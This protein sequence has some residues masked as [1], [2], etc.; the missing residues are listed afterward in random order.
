M[1]F[2]LSKI[3]SVFLQPLLW[4]LALLLYS[5][6]GKKTLWKR[7]SLRLGVALLIVLTN[8]LLF[9]ATMR[10][11]EYKSTD[12]EAITSPYDVG[13]LLGGY[14]NSYILPEHDRHN[15]NAAANR[16]TQTLELYRQGKIKKILLSGGSGKIIP[17]EVLE[18][19]KA[20]TLLLRLGIP[21]S[22]ILVESK[23]RNTYENAQFSEKIIQEHLPGAKCLLLTSAW[24]MPRAEGCFRHTQLDVTPFSVDYHSEKWEWSLNKTIVPNA[25]VL[26]RWEKLI[27]EWVGYLAYWFQGYL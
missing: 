12:A 5:L 15:F 1:F 25:Y 7:R 8:P 20:K 22:D 10:A 2:Y 27:K 21:E 16:F 26:Y 11:W 4:L 9:N 18:A 3:L 14:T 17:N 23:S 19:D 13:I 6:L 24:H